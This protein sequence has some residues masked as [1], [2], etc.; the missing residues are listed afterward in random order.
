MLMAAGGKRYG[1]RRCAAFNTI[2]VTGD[3]LGSD[4]TVTDPVS[5]DAAAAL[6]ES[7]QKAMN[8]PCVNTT[9]ANN[10]RR[11]CRQRCTL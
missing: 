2:D 3:P 1:Q 9:T 11:M 10:A 6:S 5:G 7:I 8:P 4:V